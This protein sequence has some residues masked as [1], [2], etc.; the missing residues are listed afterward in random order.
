MTNRNKINP[1]TEKGPD[2]YRTETE[3]E[4]KNLSKSARQR[5]KWIRH[6]VKYR[7]ARLTCRHFG[8]SPDTFYLW[9]KRFDQDNLSTLEDNS[10][11][12]RPHNLRTSKHLVTQLETIRKL[13]NM[14]PRLGK[15]RIAKILQ[16]TG[17]KISPSTITRI[18]KKK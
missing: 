5:L 14:D 10:A 18:L 3:H 6:F 12:R 17:Y 8:I 16:E 7:N 1:T 2:T 11:T 13:K 4:A 15:I 9:A